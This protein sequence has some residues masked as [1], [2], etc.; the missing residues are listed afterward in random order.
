M[1]KRM[2]AVLVALAALCGPVWGE[3]EDVVVVHQE[4]TV[5]VKRPQPKNSGAV[6]AVLV[7]QNHASDEFRKP[8]SN[9]GDRVA[10]ALGGEVFNLIDPNDAVGDGQNRGPWGENMPLSSAT[11]LAENLGAQT[12][13][14]AS[15]DEANVVGFGAPAR[16]QAIQS[17]GSA[18]S[19]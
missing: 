19:E 2:I 6:D 7:V 13:V 10:A 9:I 1:T 5:V 16:A 12:L 11:R 17:A 18:L 3:D 4:Q 8:L 15:V 14:T